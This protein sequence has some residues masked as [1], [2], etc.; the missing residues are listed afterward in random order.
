MEVLNILDSDRKPYGIIC[1]SRLWRY[2]KPKLQ[3]WKYYPI[4]GFNEDWNKPSILLIRTLGGV[5]LC[6][7]FDL[8]TN[9]NFEIELIHDVDEFLTKAAELTGFNYE[10]YSKDEG[11]VK[12][13]IKQLED[14][15][16]IPHGNLLII[17]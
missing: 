2:I 8:P 14:I 17:E 4:K 5:G 1:N 13:T 16:D 6:N 9:F 11:M 12:L 3:E 10:L 7:K 15:L